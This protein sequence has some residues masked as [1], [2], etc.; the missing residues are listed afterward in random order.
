MEKFHC[1]VADEVCFIGVSRPNGFPECGGGTSGKCVDHFRSHEMSS[2][3]AGLENRGEK[4]SDASM[5][6]GGANAA[7]RAHEILL[8]FRNFSLL[9]HRQRG[10][11]DPLPCAAL[12][13]KN[14]LL[15]LANFLGGKMLTFSQILIFSYPPFR[16][17]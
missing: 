4:A 1:L 2:V 12:V 16:L 15:G 13:F 11:R 8:R 7:V 9:V 17:V 14:R 5:S 10:H 6:V 3:M